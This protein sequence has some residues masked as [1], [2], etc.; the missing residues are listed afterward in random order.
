MGAPSDAGGVAKVK[1]NNRHSTA[2]HGPGKERKHRKHR[3]HGS[4]GKQKHH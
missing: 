1:P 3:K 2:R 4:K